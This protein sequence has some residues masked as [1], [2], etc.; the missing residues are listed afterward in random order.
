[1]KATHLH[2]AGE[3]LKYVTV[4]PCKLA[5]PAHCVAKHDEAGQCT[6]S[7]GRRARCHQTHTYTYT[8]HTSWLGRPGYRR[9]DRGEQGGR[10]A[11]CGG[12]DEEKRGLLSL[13]FRRLS[14]LGR[15]FAHNKTYLE[16][17]TASQHFP[18]HAS[19]C[20]RLSFSTLHVTPEVSRCAEIHL[21]PEDQMTSQ[22]WHQL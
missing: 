17:L 1:M 5:A 18:I 4:C 21:L 3:R 9:G 13:F 7:S 20:T 10:A 16:E 15:P 6:N 11:F 14:L 2:P 22:A 19:F 8:R 12:R